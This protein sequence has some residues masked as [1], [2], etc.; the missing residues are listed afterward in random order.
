[1]LARKNVEVNRN[2]FKISKFRNLNPP[3]NHLLKFASTE[4]SKFSKSFCALKTHD[5]VNMQHRKTQEQKTL[6]FASVVKS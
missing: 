4:V 6:E 1:M 5:R 3:I 2:T